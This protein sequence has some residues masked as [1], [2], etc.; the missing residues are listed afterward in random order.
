MASTIYKSITIKDAKTL[1]KGDP[2]A[3]WSAE[4]LTSENLNNVKAQ[5][6]YYTAGG[7]TCTNKPSGVDAFGLLVARTASGWITQ[8]LIPSNSNTNKMFMRTFNSSAWGAWVEKGSTGPK[9]DTGSKG[10]T[11]PQGP[12]GPQGDTGPQGVKG[13]TGSVAAVTVSGSG[14]ALTDIKLNAD[15]TITATKSTIDY[16]SLANPPTIPSITVSNSTLTISIS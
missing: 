5:N 11:G 8:L 4:Q 1:L 10:D 3:S 6:F 9:G 13:D 12:T 16:N 2:G 7:N 15:K 14:N